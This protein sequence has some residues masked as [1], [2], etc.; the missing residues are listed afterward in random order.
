MLSEIS[1][2]DREEDSESSER[3]RELH[4]LLNERVET[5]G[6]S[7][8]KRDGKNGLGLLSPSCCWD[9]ARREKTDR[10]RGLTRKR[11]NRQAARLQKKDKR[12]WLG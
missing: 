3:T 11:T 8:L 7:S 1:G 9:L 12:M 10:G 4:D 6:R 2:D 5:G